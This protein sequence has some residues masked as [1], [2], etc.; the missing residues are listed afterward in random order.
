M[1]NPDKNNSISQSDELRKKGYELYKKDKYFDAINEYNR[2]LVLARDDDV[3]KSLCYKRRAAV[4]LKLEYFEH[5][6]HNIELAVPHCPDSKL[7]KLHRLLEKCQ[8]A[9]KTT[10]DA[11]AIPFKHEFK[12][13][14]E[15][16]PKIPFFIDA[17]ELK[18]D[19]VDGKHMITTKDLKAGD[20]VAVIDEPLR[21]SAFKNDQKAM[22]GCFTCGD[23]N[24]GDLIPGECPG[25]TSK[26][27]NI[28]LLVCIK[29][30]TLQLFAFQVSFAVRNACWSTKHTLTSIKSASRSKMNSFNLFFLN[31]SLNLNWLTLC[32]ASPTAK[33]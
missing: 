10:A 20:V 14:Y 21:L 9:M 7:F 17:L 24:Y 25:T 30:R 19:S 5:C 31:P 23:K 29:T 13:S 28:I 18:E 6:M 12:L 33:R 26:V 27:D 4:F 16:N 22:M 8:E 32:P 1:L 2:A 15:A 3:R 11:G